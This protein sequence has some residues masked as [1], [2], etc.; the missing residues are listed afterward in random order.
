MRRESRTF[1]FLLI[2]ATFFWLLMM[3]LLIQRSTGFGFRTSGSD[4]PHSALRTPY[5]EE[6]LKGVEW[7]GI[8]LKGNKI[9]YVMSLTDTTEEGDL[10][11]IERTSI[12]ISVM[13]TTQNVRTYLSAI[14]DT[15]YAAKSF[16][17]EL[18][19]RGRSHKVDGRIEGDE[20]LVTIQT[21]GVR[22]EERFTLEETYLPLSI[23]ALVARRG[24]QEG[25]R[26]TFPLFDPTTLAPGEM[27][28]LVGELEEVNLRATPESP[29]W[30]TGRKLTLTFLGVE[31]W[32]W[33]DE[34]G[35]VL[36]EEG[37]M[38]MVMVR[39]TE[40]EAHRFSSGEPVEILTLFSIPS[41]LSIEN[42]RKAK[43]LKVKLEGEGL[44]GLP[45]E[46]ERQRVKTLSDGLLLE[47]AQGSFTNPESRITNPAES[48][49][50]PT[51]LI[52][53]EDQAI[54]KLAKE[55]IGPDTPES[56][57]GDQWKQVEQINNWVYENLAKVPTISIPS[58]LDVLKTKEGDCNEHSILFTALARA[59]G[60]P[61][62]I[63]VG[64]VYLDGFFYYHS[65]NRVYV[66]GPESGGWIDTDPTF[67]Q[68]R[69]DAT[70]IKLTEGGL[71]R[72]AELANL[73][74]KL[75]I[76]VLEY[77]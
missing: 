73:I 47:I 71:E 5:L 24:L 11:L 33:V 32:V 59:V 30:S 43:F 15:L 35:K 8:Y 69:A 2:G 3:G 74:G 62:K 54:Q 63:A 45:I 12:K 70:H 37:P 18:S 28:V 27:S 23:E 72:Q 44:V 39:E 14:A 57:E 34:K 38:G 9:G 51:S 75:K 31:S 66:N 64:V 56:G 50:T 48:D 4:T 1:K 25:D 26:F 22:K 58:A 36:R 10:H 67:G 53:S 29:H 17:F 46:D 61:T 65:W 41:N 16:S 77:R 76:E 19:T 7:M 52:Q 20:L 49:L 42:P 40:E 6:G 21:G 60:I 68:H 13:G 55:I